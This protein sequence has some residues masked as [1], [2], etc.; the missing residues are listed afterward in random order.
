ME[1]VKTLKIIQSGRDEGKVIHQGHAGW[2]RQKVDARPGRLTPI[3]CASHP[4]WRKD[5]A[6]RA[7][8]KGWTPLL[9]LLLLLKLLLLLHILPHDAG[10]SGAEESGPCRLHFVSD[11]FYSLAS[12][13]C[14]LL[15]HKASGDG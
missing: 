6:W 9:L 1:L 7:Q 14:K 2:Q 11:V 3:Q 15:G 10:P 8:E 12:A 4:A 5:T 13:E